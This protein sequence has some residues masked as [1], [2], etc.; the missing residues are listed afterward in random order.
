MLSANNAA[1]CSFYGL[2]PILLPYNVSHPKVYELLKATDANALICAAGSLPLDDL[3]QTCPSIRLV[4]WVVEKTS[5]HMDWNGVPDSARGR[6]SVGVWHDIVE[7]NASAATPVL[8]SNDDGDAPG[9][10]I[11]ISQNLNGLEKPPTI[12]T[13]SHA[14]FA[15]SIA[16]LISALP[17]RQ[18]FSPADLVLPASSLNIS[19]VLCQTFAALYTHA[20]LAIT[21][22]AEPGVDLALT[23][24]GI[25]PTVI[26]ASAETMA[27][28]HAQETKDISSAIQ[29][30][31]KASQ[32]QTMSAGR[33]PTDTLLFRLL[34]PSSSSNK[35]GQLRLILTSE[36][37]GAGTPPLTSTMLSDLR[38]FTRARIVYALTAPSV[39]GA[40]AQTNVFDYRREDGQGLAPFG[41]PVSSVEVKLKGPESDGKLGGNAPEGDVVVAGPA[42]AGEGEKG[43]A[44]LGVKG[45]FREDGTLALI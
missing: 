3:C 36:R 10:I 29:K 22:V 20:S 24:R 15:S 33:M 32:A 40:V 2:T 16:S 43:E 12:T 13:F 25:S 6:L 38:I 28:L 8:P 42:V 26:I 4:T 21:S 1:A 37:L 35:P 30:V 17:L 14:N 5:R 31:S 9:K 44:G 23:Q 45:R 19:Y 34:A 27:K 11:T 7:E 41:V 39:C 18:R